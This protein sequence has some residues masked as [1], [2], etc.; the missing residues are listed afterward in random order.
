MSELLAQSSFLDEVPH[1]KGE[2]LVPDDATLGYCQ[3]CGAAII[4]RNSAHG[5]ALP[6]SAATIAWRGGQ[7]Y[8]LSHFADCKDANEWRRG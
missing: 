5:R 4:W 7:R 3:S 6:L 8:A 1:R 2:H